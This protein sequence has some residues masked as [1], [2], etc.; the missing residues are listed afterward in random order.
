M[1]T[2]AWSDRFLT[3][4][5]TVDSEHRE[6]VRIINWVGSMHAKDAQSEDIEKVLEE[7]VQYAV[8]HF[9]HE[10]ELM[11]QAGCDQRHVELHQR[12]HRDFAKQIANMRQVKAGSSD[13]EFLLRFLT[14]WLAY[15]ILGT[16]QAM[17]RQVQNIRR[18]M[19][20]V[21]AYAAEQAL[22]ADPATASLLDALNSLYRVIAGRNQALVDLNLRLEDRVNERTRELSEANRELL[23]EQSKLKEAMA[24]LE[25]TQ[26]QLLESERKSASLS[27]QRVVQQLLSQI[28]DGDP[29]PTLVINA[30]HKVTH[31]NKACAAVTGVPASEMLRTNRQWAPFYASE[32]PILAD[33]IVS[34]ALQEGLENHYKGK[35][36]PSSLIE[37][38]FEAEDFYPHFGSSGRW[39]Y[40]TAAPLKDATGRIVGAIETLQDVTERHKA[41]DALRNYQAQLED[42]VEKRTSQLQEANRRLAQ[43]N[44][45][46]ERAEQ[47]LRRRYVELTELNIQLS[48]TREQLV[49]SEKLASIGQLAAGVAH[50][51]NNPIGYV[52]SNIGSLEKYIDDLFS[53]MK[54]YQAAESV[55]PQPQAGELAGLRKKVDF[56]FLQED[57]P[58]LMGES[59]EGISRVKKIVQDLKD[60]S[61]VDSS[62]EWQ[63]AN[64]HQGL[65]STI[66]IAANEIKY[67]ADVVKEY[68]NLPEVECMPSQ[69]NQV[70]M[71]LLVNAAHAMGTERGRI[72]VRTGVSGDKVWVEIADSGCG[73]PEEI[74]QKIFDPFF[75]TKPV[76]KGTGL[77]LSL[78]YGIIQNHN[79]RIEL[80][81]VVGQGS[82]FRITLP[83]QHTPITP[84]AAGGG[85]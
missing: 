27:A 64:L 59:K 65:D 22:V 56:D 58:V 8:V 26:Q 50:E 69:L 11:A 12:I 48:D 84:D 9:S 60:F 14:N 21:E 77:G 24:N 53:L 82:T 5:G 63:W 23:S 20:P 68:G 66:N 78:S 75:T 42:L 57:I 43:D 32:R 18:G 33:L 28:V 80:D 62:Q 25:R 51:I 6:L 71:N 55:I 54:A 30:E 4:E 40:F 13:T 3:G 39:L 15:H 7:L 17:A 76:G 85:Q 49:Q 37:G 47:E 61:R 1:E 16:D 41:E 29:V 35:Y 38:A 70:F 83:I 79:G 81:S 44:A 31:W 74:R 34:G 72:T 46:R 45:E 19:T 52:Y 2:F 36:R 10:E 73:I 67:K